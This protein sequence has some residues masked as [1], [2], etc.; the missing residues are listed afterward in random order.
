MNLYEQQTT[1]RRT[2]W[3]IMIAFVA[4]VLVLGLGFDGFYLGAASG[5][6]VLSRSARSRRSASA[7]P[8]AFASYYNGDRAV[9]AATSAAPIE[10]VA[11]A[12]G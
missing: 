7:P 6:A 3:L 1:N 4:L 11:A 2:T 8:S 9:L 5:R 10:E 12:A